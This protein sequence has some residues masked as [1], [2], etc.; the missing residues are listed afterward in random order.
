[1]QERTKKGAGEKSCISEKAEHERG[2]DGRSAKTDCLESVREGRCQIKGRG[3]QGLEH[4]GKVS[5]VLLVKELYLYPLSPYMSLKSS[6]KSCLGKFTQK[7]LYILE[8]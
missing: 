6:M 8:N 3:R 5:C 2:C 1:M 7:S 4:A